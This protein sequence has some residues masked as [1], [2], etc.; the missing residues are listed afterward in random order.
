MLTARV[1]ETDQLIGLGGRRRLYPKPFHVVVVV[2][3]LCPPERK[4]KLPHN[5]Y[6]SPI[7]RSTDGHT[8]LVLACL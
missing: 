8:V 6:V 3:V 2:C 4:R 7:L 5:G 1:E